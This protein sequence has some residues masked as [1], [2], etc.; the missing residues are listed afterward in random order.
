MKKRKYDILFA[1]LLLCFLLHFA[2]YPL[3]IIKDQPLSGYY[4]LPE[5]VEFSAENYFSRKYQDSTEKHIK[6]TFGLFPGF[7]RIHHQIEYSFF[8]RLHVAD[9]HIGSK[10]YLFRYCEGCITGRTY[11]SIAL[12]SYLN[13]YL[14]LQDSLKAAGKNIVWV[15][16]PDKNIVYSE[17]LPASAK[18]PDKVY[19]FYWD[20]QK[21]FKKKG[22]A[23][24]DFNELAFREKNTY[25]Y[26][27]YNK[28]GVHW[29]NAY[30][31]R[32][33]DSV[34]SYLG[35]KTSIKIRNTIVF[36]KVEHP[37]DPD[38]DM[39]AAANLLLPLEQNGLYLSEISSVSNAK[40]KKILLIGD[41]FAHAWIWTKWYKNCFH[42]DSEFWYYN[43]E[44][45]TLDNTFKRNVDHKDARKA[46]AGFDTFVIVFS[47]ANAE[48]LDYDFIND[49]YP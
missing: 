16:A 47:A 32:C 17:Y 35:Q 43:R 13:K 42:Q 38:I 39:E 26:Q 19:G 10:G 7:T 27:V 31:A 30:A 25:P 1:F 28:G 14:L 2:F 15:I 24:I 44:A 41:S 18:A 46:I 11:D 12:N 33:F 34:C 36:N 45:N 23:F 48:N 8:D 6:Y 20:L 40:N 21:A 29:T 37:W 4:K 5:K 9:V 49:L 3:G 22:I